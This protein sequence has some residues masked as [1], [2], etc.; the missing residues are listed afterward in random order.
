MVFYPQD[1]IVY[2]EMVFKIP[3]HW[4]NVKKN[5]NAL[6]N[7]GLVAYQQNTYNLDI[8]NSIHHPKTDTVNT[9]KLM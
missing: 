2:I 7:H 3:V 1:V 6:I 4:V 8:Q 5:P 9:L